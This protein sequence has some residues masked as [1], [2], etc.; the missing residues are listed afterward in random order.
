[1]EGRA[2][3]Q[4]PGPMQRHQPQLCNYF[5]FITLLAKKHPPGVPSF[6]LGNI[7][8]MAEAAAATAATTATATA[9]TS[10]A[11]GVVSKQICWE[12]RGFT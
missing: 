11:T 4:R 5:K 3:M 1:M 9:E 10:A 8:K 12:N 7:E 6:S 2:R